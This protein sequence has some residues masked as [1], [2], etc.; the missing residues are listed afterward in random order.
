[1]LCIFFICLSYYLFPFQLCLCAPALCSRALC[2]RF[3]GPRTCCSLYKEDNTSPLSVWLILLH[4]SGVCLD[5]LCF[6]NSPDCEPLSAGATSTVC[7]IESTVL[8]GARHTMGAR[9]M[10]FERFAQSWKQK[11][12]HLLILKPFFFPR[13]CS[14]LG[15]GAGGAIIDPQC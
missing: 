15:S 13:F 3:Q 2:A 11:S 5:I 8:P 4:L 9:Q 14:G 12:S 10:L 6:W 1:M 7:V